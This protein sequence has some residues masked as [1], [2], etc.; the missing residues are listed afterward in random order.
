MC[1]CVFMCMGALLACVP[2]CLCAWVFCVHVCL[3]VYVH[4]CFAC[5]CACVKELN[6]LELELQAAVSCHVVAGN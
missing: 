2:V 5:M 6:S 1:A 3:C 4:G